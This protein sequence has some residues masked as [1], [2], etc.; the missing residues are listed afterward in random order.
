MP[1]VETIVCPACRAENDDRARYCD[2]CGRR[3]AAPEP[4]ADGD[5]CPA[6][7]GRLEDLGGARWR[8]AQCGL[9][10]KESDPPEADPANAGEPE[11]PAN[12]VPCP[13]CGAETRDDASRCASCGI[14]YDAPRAP[15][16]CP[17]CGQPAGPDDCACGAI[18][19]LD[20]LL[21]FVGPSVR[22]VCVRCKAPYARLP[23]GALAKCPDCGGGLTTADR[24]KAFRR[25]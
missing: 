15:Q 18:L 21:E 8:C 19:S 24:L 13:L 6:C 10:M 4:S 11:T 9:E 12:M 5:A 7:G 23:D 16:P 17:R 22:F 25:G 20:K 2:Q 14:W 3:V 1:V